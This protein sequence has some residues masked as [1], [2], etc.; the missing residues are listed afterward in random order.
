MIFQ[1]R[2]K[3]KQR[4]TFGDCGT[5]RVW[6]CFAE[7]TRTISRSADAVSNSAESRKSVLYPF[8]RSCL[9]LDGE[10]P[11]AAIHEQ[12]FPEA[13]KAFTSPE[14]PYWIDSPYSG[15]GLDTADQTVGDVVSCPCL[16]QGH[17]RTYEIRYSTLATSGLER[18]ILIRIMIYAADGLS[19]T[20]SWSPYL[21]FP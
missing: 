12:I 11:A 16:T 1:N 7:E 2:S 15:R 9:D 14:I 5:T 19:G 10:L 3:P 17:C 20:N 21:N 8:S 18:A 4:T 6:F 13:V